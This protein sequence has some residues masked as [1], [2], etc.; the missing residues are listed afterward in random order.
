MVMMRFRSVHI[1]QVIAPDMVRYAE[2]TGNSCLVRLPAEHSLDLHDMVGAGRVIA[3]KDFTVAGMP[4][5][6]GLEERVNEVVHDKSLVDELLLEV[7]GV[8]DIAGHQ[9]E[10]IG[11]ADGAAA[12]AGRAR[13]LPD[14]A[15]YPDETPGKTGAHDRVLHILERQG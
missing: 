13:G 9:R 3:A 10:Y 4:G 15:G 1:V 8:Q 5:L 14:G 6:D 11:A 7:G 2:T 12:P